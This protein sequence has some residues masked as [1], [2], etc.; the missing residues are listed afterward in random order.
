MISLVPNRQ[1][2]NTDKIRKGEQETILQGRTCPCL[3]GGKKRKSTKLISCSVHNRSQVDLI[4]LVLKTLV[5]HLG[6]DLV[7]RVLSKGI[8]SLVKI[9]Y[10]TASHAH[11]AKLLVDSWPSTFLL[12]KEVE[13][14]GSPA[15]EVTT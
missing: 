9:C 10:K 14:G 8:N 3:L 2:A 13:S 5:D 12:G 7:Q 6:S 1:K 15:I 11:L 4:I